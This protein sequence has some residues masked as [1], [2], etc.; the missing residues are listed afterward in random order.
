[1][2]STDKLAAVREESMAVVTSKDDEEVKVH[3]RRHVSKE[4]LMVKGCSESHDPRGKEM[5][6]VSLGH[7]HI[8]VLGHFHHR[9]EFRAKSI[10]GRRWQI[11]QGMLC[12]KPVLKRVSSCE[13]VRSC[14]LERMSAM[15]FAM[16]LM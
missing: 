15:A 5:G 14:C 11:C 10:M 13:S 2:L 16:L 6:L 3:V 4:G 9:E 12:G 1:M 7:S 8:A